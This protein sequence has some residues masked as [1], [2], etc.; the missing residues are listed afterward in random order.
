MRVTFWGSVRGR[1]LTEI[2]KGLE[3]VNQVP[4]DAPTGVCTAV[5]LT[6]QGFLTEA[7]GQE[8][9]RLSSRVSRVGYSDPSREVLEA[10]T[11]RG[12]FLWDDRRTDQGRL[13]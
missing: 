1:L 6:Y 8:E 11:A 9:L 12:C 5:G 4:G 3:G 7:H 2:G 10:A 13:F